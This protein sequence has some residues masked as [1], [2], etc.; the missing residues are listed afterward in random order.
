MP[1]ENSTRKFNKVK[2]LPDMCNNPII[3]PSERLNMIFMDL[4]DALM[5]PEPYVPSIQY[6]T[7]LHDAIRC[8]QTLLCRDAQGKQII[9]HPDVPLPPTRVFPKR[10]KGPTTLLQTYQPETVGTIV[11]KK[12]D[13]DGKYYEGEVSKYDA[14]NKFYL[15]KYFDG[16]E[17]DFD[18]Q[19]MKKYK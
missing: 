2:F 7:E 1:L 4:V 14:I 13:E 19:E 12:F 18:H 8:L 6:G 17:E 9:A 3:T 10:D 16:D 5:A 15:I 11:R